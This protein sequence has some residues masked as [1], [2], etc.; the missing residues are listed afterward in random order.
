MVIAN[1]MGIFLTRIGAENAVPFF[2]RISG[3]MIPD[4]VFSA[5]RVAAVVVEGDVPVVE[6]QYAFPPVSPQIPEGTNLMIEN[7]SADASSTGRM[8]RSI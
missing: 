1:G 8:N 2:I 3:S 6:G 4:T 5:F 7:A